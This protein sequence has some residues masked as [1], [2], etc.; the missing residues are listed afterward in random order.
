MSSTPSSNTNK[1]FSLQIINSEEKSYTWKLSVVSNKLEIY[2]SNDNFLSL[3]YKASFQ[4][5]DLNKLNNFL[6]NLN[7]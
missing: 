6:D 7:Q 1:S 5:E 3:S 2:I 4:I